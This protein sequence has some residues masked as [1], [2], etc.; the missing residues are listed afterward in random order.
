[1][2]SVKLPTDAPHSKRPKKQIQP[3]QN[4]Q[5]QHHR[6]KTPTHPKHIEKTNKK[7][8]KPTTKTHQPPLPKNQ[9]QTA[10]KC[11][12]VKGWK[13]ESEKGRKANSN[14]GLRVKIPIVENF[15][16]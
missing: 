3:P 2:Q 16:I 13:R 8:P 6:T 12:F 10:L 1:M 11:L 5:N 7:P 9:S 15:F 4:H 14:K